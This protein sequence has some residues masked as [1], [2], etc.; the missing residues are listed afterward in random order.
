MIQFR[1]LITYSQISVQLVFI[2][3]TTHIRINIFSQSICISF[4]ILRPWPKITSH[5]SMILEYIEAYLLLHP[6]SCFLNCIFSLRHCS[7]STIWDCFYFAI[8][9]RNLL[10]VNLALPFLQRLTQAA[11]K[12]IPRDDTPVSLAFVKKKMGTKKGTIQRKL[13]VWSI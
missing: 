8:A 10:R 5:I 3:D 11:R 2:K 4:K 1:L 9:C 12:K 7:Y 6:L 13:V